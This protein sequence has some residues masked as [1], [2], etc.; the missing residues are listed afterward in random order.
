M[1]LLRLLPAL[2]VAAAL[3]PAGTAQAAD[4]CVEP[5]ATCDPAFTHGDLESAL[6]AATA[7]GGDDR[8]LLPAGTFT[9]STTT[10]FNAYT[11][12][13]KIEIIG[14]GRDK[15]VL[16]APAGAQRVLRLS[17]TNGASVVKDLSVRIPDDAAAG[18]PGLDLARATVERVSVTRTPTQTNQASGIRINSGGTVDDTTISLTPHIAGDYGLQLGGTEGTVTDVAVDASNGITL[19]SGMDAT[20]ERVRINHT[21]SGMAVT[22]AHAVVRNALTTT[23]KGTALSVLDQPARDA[24]VEADHLTLIGG[25]TGTGISASNTL[26]NDDEDVKV[27]VRNSVIRGFQRALSRS[28]TAGQS[29]VVDLRTAWSDYDASGER[30]KDSDGPGTL[31]QSERSFH[32]DAGFSAD[33]DFRLAAGSPLVDAGDPDEAPGGADLAGAERVTDGDGDGVART[34]I[35]AFGRPA[36][37]PLGGQTPPMGGTPG[38]GGSGAPPAPT[39]AP[40]SAPASPVATTAPGETATASGPRTAPSTSQLDRRAPKI[41]RITVRRLRGGRLQVRFTLSERAAVTVKAG[42]T[43]RRIRSARPGRVTVTLKARRGRV[44]VVAVDAAGN[45]AQRRATATR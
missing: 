14:A 41:G 38:P 7:A 21:Q 44:T 45:R 3:V 33:G 8:I 28:S 26:G 15:T 17:T 20:I 29:G 35:G 39:P 2:G 42:R 6:T 23:T 36:P 25:A 16:T 5:L 12:A 13:D 32:P 22:G 9:A 4:H 43:T 30:V 18:A 27:S 40:P 24:G 31:T 1:K 11:L 37:D 10:G 34:D 19:L